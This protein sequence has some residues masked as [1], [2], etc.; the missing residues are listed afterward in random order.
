MCIEEEFEAVLNKYFDEDDEEILN[1][2]TL[3]D[4]YNEPEM[5]RT[6]IE[7]DLS[8]TDVNEEE[9]INEFFSKDCCKKKCHTVIPRKMITNTRNNCLELSKNKL[10]L[11]ILSQFET[12]M[13][14]NEE[15]DLFFLFH[16]EFFYVYFLKTTHIINRIEFFKT[17]LLFFFNF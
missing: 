12:G 17:V 5:E 16:Y 4:D 14:C 2:G 11:V 9:L 8:I 10:D 6:F 7:M 13:M 15:L 1:D 3:N